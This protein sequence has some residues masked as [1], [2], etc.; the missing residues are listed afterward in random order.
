MNTTCGIIDVVLCSSHF[1]CSYC[2]CRLKLSTPSNWTTSTD[3]N[4]FKGKAHRP[5]WTRFCV[6]LRIGVTYTV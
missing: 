3:A 1:Y 5:A 4:P 6:H 2:L